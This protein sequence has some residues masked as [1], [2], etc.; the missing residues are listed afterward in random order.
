MNAMLPRLFTAADDLFNHLCSDQMDQ[1]MWDVERL[2]FKKVFEAYRAHYL[3]LE[4]D[5]VVAPA[6]VA[7]AMQLDKT[8]ELWYKVLRVVSSANL[9]TL[10]NDITPIKQEQLIPL[11]QMWESNFYDSVVGV[12]NSDNAM[13][14]GIV[15]QILMIRTQLSIATLEHLHTTNS[16]PFHPFEKVAEFWCDGRVSLESVEAFLGNNKDA[17]QLKPIVP[18]NSEAAALARVRNPARFHSICT[19]LPNQL[20]EGYNLNL[21]PLHDTYPLSEFVDNLRTFV[22]VCFARTKALLQQDFAQSD[23]ASGAGSQIRSQLEADAMGFDRAESGYVS[24]FRHRL[25]TS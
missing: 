8:S 13:N 14:E 11:L 10:L 25:V 6:F 9:A 21:N 12:N 5:P 1:E 15:E 3:L 20:I 22:K 18:A 17:L 19:H 24:C 4:G 23:A 7:G 2:A 16:G